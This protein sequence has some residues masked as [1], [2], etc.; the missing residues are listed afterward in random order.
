[1]TTWSDDVAEAMAYAVAGKGTAYTARVLA[2]EVRRLRALA[3]EALPAVALRCPQCGIVADSAERRL[4]GPTRYRHGQL[5]HV[6]S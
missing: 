4:G 2:S 3:G 5:E 6:A 1:M